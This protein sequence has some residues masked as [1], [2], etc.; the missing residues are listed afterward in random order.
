MGDRFVSEQ[1]A[2]KEAMHCAE[3]FIRA[4]TYYTVVDQDFVDYVSVTPLGY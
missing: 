1:V 4:K 3:L 2:N